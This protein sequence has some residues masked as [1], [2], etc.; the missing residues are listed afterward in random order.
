VEWSVTLIAADDVSTAVTVTENV[1]GA[2][3][4]ADFRLGRFDGPAGP[5]QFGPAAH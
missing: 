3:L 5:I 2:M 4:A 1:Y